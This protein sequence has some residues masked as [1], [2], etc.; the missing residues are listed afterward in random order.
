MRQAAAADREPPDAFTSS[1][2][3]PDRGD[4]ATD[5]LLKDSRPH[6][7]GNYVNAYDRLDVEG[8]YTF[9]STFTA[10]SPTAASSRR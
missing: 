1:D 6:A 4:G 8:T 7:A 5:E 2:A 10:R 3:G 9:G